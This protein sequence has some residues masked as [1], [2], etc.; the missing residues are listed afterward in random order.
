MN[1]E[2]NI[3]NLNKDN[4]NIGAR[5]P[6]SLF[7]D[8]IVNIFKSIGWDLINGPE[9]ESSY[10][11]FDA[12]NFPS[13]HPARDM[14]D[15]FFLESE[16]LNLIKKSRQPIL[17]THTSPVQIRILQKNGNNPIYAISLG[18]VYRR[19]SLDDTH[20]S[21]FNQFEGIALDR[22]LNMSHMI[23][24]L[25]I[26]SRK[27]FDKKIKIKLRPSFFPF[28]EPSAELDVLQPSDKEKE[29]EKWIEWGGCGMI[30][31]NV[32]KFSNI[33]NKKFSGFAFGIGIERTLMIVNKIKNIKYLIE[34]DVRFSQSY[35]MVI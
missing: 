34:G 33:D 17:R 35:G 14:Q 25:N 10:F 5:H 21:V 26:V 7:E 29:E 15:T 22:E 19:D 30:H 4:F 31:P 12:L 9:L 3:F 32:L 28:T 27:I 13:D 23:G 1:K 6:I 20:T 2:I 11:N 18:R 16:N 24:I 8:K